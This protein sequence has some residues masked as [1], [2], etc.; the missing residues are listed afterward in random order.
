ML[1]A[2]KVIGIFGPTISEKTG[3]AVNLAKY[4]WGKY[5]LE[6][7][8]VSADSR[9]V[10]NELKIGQM[11]LFPQYAAKIK[12]HCTGILDS[13]EERITLYEYKAMAERSI[14]GI[15]E[16]GHFPIIYG[17]GAVWISSVLENWN[18]PN[19]QDDGI[20]F[21]RAFGQSARKYQSVILIPD[22]SKPALFKKI[23]EHTRQTIKAGILDEL[24]LLVA[25]YQIDP[26]L[27]P[28]DNMLFKVVEYREFLEYCHR[29]KKDLDELDHRDIEQIRVTIASDLK[30]LARRQL[31]WIP[32]MQGEKYL[33]KSWQEA[34][35]IVDGFLLA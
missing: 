31:R 7:E 11:G 26:L 22:I 17:G 25:K 15:L 20:D 19:K 2:N 28:T 9:K 1:L 27:S 30:D 34:R 32:K 24:K 33:I 10:Y 14:D 29:R 3:L 6:V 8:L 16:R 4:I 23:E 35:K 5:N 13:L 21:K 12:L 18:V